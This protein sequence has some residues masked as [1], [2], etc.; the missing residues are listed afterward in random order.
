MLTGKVP[1]TMSAN[2]KLFNR[3]VREKVLFDVHPYTYL[4]QIDVQPIPAGSLMPKFEG[5]KTI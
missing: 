4:V 2:V 5:L 3:E 1:H